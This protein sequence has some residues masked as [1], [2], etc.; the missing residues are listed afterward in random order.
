MIVLMAAIGRNRELGFGNKLPWHLPD[1]LKR[2]KEITRGH[3][4]IMGRKTYESI[5]KALPERK[6]IVITRNADYKA[7]GAVV[8][9]SIE[10]AFKET[11]AAAGEDVF[12]IG[13]GEIYR[14]AL[15]YADK[16]YLTFVDAEIP[17]DTYFPE[18]NENE[19]RITGAVPHEADE[20]HAHR[21]VFKT[22]ERK[23]EN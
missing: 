21:F 15:P 20:K 5:G 4:I 11:G 10:E 12:V 14:L 1:D 13:G 17:A 18:F 22:Y 2:F 9:G 7:P 19:W 6:N 3:S 23:K 16:M 8:V